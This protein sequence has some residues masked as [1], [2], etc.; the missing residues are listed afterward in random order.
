MWYRIPE[1]PTAPCSSNLRMVGGRVSNRTAFSLGLI[2]LASIT[3]EHP[4]A[5]A[6][7]WQ[8][9]S[10]DE[11]KMSSAP[12]APGAPAIYLYRQ[13]E[14]DDQRGNPHEYNYAR[15]KILTEEGRKYGDIEIPFFKQE[16]TI[17]LVKGTHDS[18]GWQ[19]C[20]LRRQTIR[21]DH[22]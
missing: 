10:Q 1:S 7:E 22:H 19:D 9:I 4:A 18:T 12:E 17:S 21:K 6:Q 2:L 8:P 5:T 3:Y 20:E 15:I 13:V 14:R 11:L 16:G